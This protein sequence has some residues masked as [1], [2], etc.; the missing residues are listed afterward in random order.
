MGTTIGAIK[1]DTR[2]LDYSSC[3]GICK[4]EARKRPCHAA[5]SSAARIPRGFRGHDGRALRQVQMTLRDNGKS[6]G[7]YYV[8]IENILGLSR[9][10]GK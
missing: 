9:D 7:N 4:Q 1:G 5:A 2:S 10:N 8:I 3:Q 6:N